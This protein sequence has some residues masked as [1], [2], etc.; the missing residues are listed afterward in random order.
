MTHLDWF[1]QY[2]LAGIFLIAGVGKIFIFHYKSDAGRSGLSGK[3]IGLTRKAVYSIS[4]LEITGAL[5]LI[6]PISF[7][8]PGLAPILSA[9]TLA[10]LMLAACVYRNR[11][12][13]FT[14]PVVALF[15]LALLVVVGH[16]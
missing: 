2:L 10:L 5:G 16:L 3:T 9:T 14:A 1:A 11:R 4:A 12:Q 8:R 6:L 13:E 7:W 15:L